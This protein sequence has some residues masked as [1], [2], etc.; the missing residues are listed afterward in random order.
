MLRTTVWRFP[1]RC[2]RRSIPR[3][4]SVL[5][6]NAV[7]GRGA[8]SRRLEAASLFASR[9]IVRVCVKPGVGSGHGGYVV[10]MTNDGEREEAGGRPSRLKQ[11]L[12]WATGDRA[13]EGRALAR[14]GGPCRE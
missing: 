3:N 9:D 1:R 5:Y 14:A 2:L 13:A 8:R 12:H 7:S 6:K 10:A 11:L 4:V